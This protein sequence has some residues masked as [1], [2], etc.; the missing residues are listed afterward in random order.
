MK[1]MVIKMAANNAQETTLQ[2][3]ILPDELCT[4]TQIY[5]RAIG[6]V[7]RIS[8]NVL[9]LPAGSIV[10]T[11]TYMNLFD[12]SAWKQYTFAQTIELWI[13][14]IGE[15][16][17]EVKSRDVEKEWLYEQITYQ[18]TQKKTIKIRLNGEISGQVYFQIHASQHTELYHASYR[19]S[20]C[21]S[22]IYLSVV[23]CTYKRKQPLLGNIEKLFQS[24]FF[25]KNDWRYH[26]LFIRVVDNASELILPGKDN[27]KLYHNPNTGGSGGFTR[28]LLETR[29]EISSF[30]T[31]HVVL[32]DDDA[33][34]QTES[35][36]RIYA[37]LS[38]IRP[39][40]KN[41]V[42]AGRMFRLD[43]PQIQYTASE[44]WNRGDILHMG[45]NLDVSKW[46]SLK[47]INW[48]RGEYS[49]WWLAVFPYEF[50]ANNLPLPFFLHCDDVEYGLRHGG[51]PIVLNGIQVWHETYEYRQSS[52]MAYYDY[53]NT[54]I[55]N[56]KYGLLKADFEKRWKKV[57]STYHVEKKWDWE[58]AIIVAMSDFLKGYNRFLKGQGSKHI[59]TKKM[60]GMR[61][62][63]AVM[64]RIVSVKLHI[65]K[66]KIKSYNAQEENWK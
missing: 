46:E 66:V 45:E 24:C 50:T 6:E 62:L 51:K 18:T 38:Y 53:R 25:D 58:L 56:A 16:I 5:Y 9:S 37:L 49:G 3:F 59:L 42:I 43:N 65:G 36:Y 1:G 28:G 39:K 57:I 40:Y 41:E 52:V 20:D 63:N 8:E 27:F 48:Q 26:K 34:F 31:S 23:I 4:E 12:I 54:L 32:M 21:A 29:N 61:V 33:M 60:F 7:K 13:E 35:L 64:W 17:I 15:G 44:V 2:N 14:L 22:P 10:A 19:C 47:D 55:V 11:N 30:P